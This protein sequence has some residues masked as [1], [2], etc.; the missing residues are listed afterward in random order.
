VRGQDSQTKQPVC[1][2][3]ELVVAKAA[4]HL[5]LLTSRQYFATR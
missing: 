4:H 1:C 5:K 2:P 3:P